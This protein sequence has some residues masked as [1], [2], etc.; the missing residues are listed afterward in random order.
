MIVTCSRCGWQQAEHRRE[1][2]RCLICA[3]KVY[4]PPIPAKRSGPSLDVLVPALV[5]FVTA[6]VAGTLGWVM[7]RGV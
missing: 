7:G 5:L 2:F 3:P 6:A 4:A 1:D